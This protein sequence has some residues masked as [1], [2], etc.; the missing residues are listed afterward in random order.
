M[1]WVKLGPLEAESP[2][3]VHDEDDNKSDNEAPSISE[4]D[5]WLGFEAASDLWTHEYHS[6][7]LP[8][9]IGVDVHLG[10]HNCPW[11]AVV[12]IGYE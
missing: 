11:Q 6:M 10:K 7:I 1:R 2:D 12:Y 5:P 3:G 9:V 4:G 8:S